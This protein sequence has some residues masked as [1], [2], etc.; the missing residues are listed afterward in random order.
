MASIIKELNEL[1]A[2][3][4]ISPQTARD[5]EGYYAINKEP[6][7]NGLLTIFGSLGAVLV[8]LGII[9]IF[10]HNWDDFSI[11]TKTILAFLPLVVSQG[12]AAFSIIKEKSSVWKNASGV[13]VF[14][15][16]G[17]AISLVAQIYNIPGNLGS[18]LFAWT[19]LCSPLIYLL[20]S[21]AVAVLHIVFATYFATEAGY[22]NPHQPWGYI[23]LIAL[24]LPYYL[25][26]LKQERN[27]TTAALNWLL[28]LSGLIVL[29]S[30]LDGAGTFG[31]LI[32]LAFAGLLQSIGFIPPFSDEPR[33]NGYLT[34]GGLSIAI[35]LIMASFRWV[36]R[37][38]VTDAV[39][40]I[41]F[42]I[43]WLM[44]YGAGIYFSFLRKGAPK[45]F[46]PF[47]TAA[48]IFP[49]IYLI[50]NFNSLVPSILTNLLVLALGISIIRAG[51]ARFDFATLNFGL[52]ITTVLIACRFFD[53]NMSFVVRGLLFIGVGV[54]FFLT[55]YF[56]IQKK[57]SNPKTTNYE[58]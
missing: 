52:T 6:Q 43:A 33:K 50:G 14:F 47:R 39:P 1:V 48:F 8:G 45:S 27:N 58:N 37:E 4:V 18:F 38:V 28:P 23:L 51:V 54:G 10:A 16:V 57:K 25:Q 9:L 30:F 56:L 7:G 34:L 24:L 12:L 2:N 32:Y 35:I 3:N 17:A 40:G 53:V 11:S 46:E 42:I 26:Q 21:N 29:G 41:P 55:N 22:F 49:V 5:I 36:W 20:R 15:S 31:F 13:L 44:L 19:L